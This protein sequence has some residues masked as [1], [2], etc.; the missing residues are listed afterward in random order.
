LDFRAAAQAFY[1]S[2]QAPLS[3]AKNAG[4]LVDLLLEVT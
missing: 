2:E 1:E 3:A 4:L